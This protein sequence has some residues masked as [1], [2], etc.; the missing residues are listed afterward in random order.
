M[1]PALE[2]QAISV[3]EP[4]F[5]EGPDTSNPG[6]RLI[7]VRT[8]THKWIAPQGSTTPTE[9]YDLRADPGETKNLDDDELREIGRRHLETYFSLAAGASPKRELD[10]RT[11]EKLRALGYV[12]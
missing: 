10:A 6:R 7:A 3:G 1:R 4:R 9:I 12:E 11:T 8:D 5:A 2:G